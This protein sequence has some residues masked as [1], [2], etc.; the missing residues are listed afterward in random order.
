MFAESFFSPWAEHHGHGGEVS[1][2][3]AEE[4]GCGPVDAVPV[5]EDGPEALR[6]RR[7]VG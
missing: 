5:E 3:E 2:G 1:R 6:A 7:L 4:D